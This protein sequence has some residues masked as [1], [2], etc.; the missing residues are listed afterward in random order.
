L[1]SVRIA[2]GRSYSQYIIG[3]ICQVGLEV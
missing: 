1:Q 3:R 2:A